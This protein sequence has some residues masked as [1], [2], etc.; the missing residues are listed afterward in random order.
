M[1]TDLIGFLRTIRSSKVLEL[2]LPRSLP[3]RPSGTLLL[4]FDYKKELTKQVSNW[5]QS[6]QNKPYTVRPGL[7]ITAAWYCY[8]ICRSKFNFENS[9]LTFEFRNFDF[10]KS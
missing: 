9:V 10:L 2:H 5:T 1:Q 8:R 6:N 3:E 7:I 4:L